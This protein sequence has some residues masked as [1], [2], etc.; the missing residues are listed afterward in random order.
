MSNATSA[1]FL[2]WLLCDVGAVWHGEIEEK[3]EMETTARRVD[4]TTCIGLLF[5]VRRGPISNTNLFQVVDP[6]SVYQV[7]P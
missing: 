3:P 1:A 2:S 6:F 4:S 5:V 7:E